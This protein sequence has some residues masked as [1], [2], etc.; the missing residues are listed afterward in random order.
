MR[1]SSKPPSAR[2]FPAWLVIPLAAG[3]G[4]FTATWPG[5]IFGLVVGTFL[6]KMRR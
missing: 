1:R 4:F 5:F 2:R 6:W 3:A